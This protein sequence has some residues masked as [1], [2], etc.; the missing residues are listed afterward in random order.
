MLSRMCFCIKELTSGIATISGKSSRHDSYEMF[1]RVTGFFTPGTIYR[2]DLKDTAFNSVLW[3]EMKVKGVDQND[4]V[5]Q[6]V[7][8]SSKD[9]T[10]V[11]MF[12][13]YKKD[14]D[15]S[16]GKNPVLLYGYGGFN[17]G[18]SDPSSN[19]VF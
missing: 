5:S 10:K 13:N 7:F 9:G 18:E 16:S 6:Q 14:L 4:F 19:I 11:P 8:Y 15:I 3:R 1:Y 12:I 17:V 2:V